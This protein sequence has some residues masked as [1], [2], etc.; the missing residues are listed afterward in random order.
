MFYTA[1]AAGADVLCSRAQD[2]FAPGVLAVAFRHGLAIMDEV[3]L[4]L[5]LQLSRLPR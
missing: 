2:F 4:L 1:I 5:A 3:Q